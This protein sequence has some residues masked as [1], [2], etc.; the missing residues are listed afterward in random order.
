MLALALVPCGACSAGAVA[1]DDSASSEDSVAATVDGHTI[2]ESTVTDHIELMRVR[3]G[4]ED[5][6]A[7]QSYLEKCDMTAQSAREYVIGSYVERFLVEDYCQQAGITVEDDEVSTKLDEMKSYYDGVGS[8][9]WQAMLDAAGYSDE[10][11]YADE[12]RFDLLESKLKEEK[13]GDIEA[14]DAEAQNYLDEHCANYD[15]KRLA[16]IVVAS[17]QVACTLQD[18]IA[19]GTLS[20]GE[21]ALTYSLMYGNSLTASGNDATVPDD[22][23]GIRHDVDLAKLTYS[24]DAEWEAALA[25]AGDAG[26]S[27]AWSATTAERYL[28]SIA[29][30]GVGEMRVVQTSLGWELLLVSDAYDSASQGAELATVPAAVVDAARADCLEAKRSDAWEAFGQSLW[31]AATIT[32][33]DM[34]DNL[35]YA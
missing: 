8:N 3:D 1:S 2:M 30:M 34:P 16:T 27:Y 32:I 22:A 23:D 17:E 4:L 7:W 29:S 26:W 19:D 10:S 21:A 33:S 28:E 5:A 12:L 11:S 31:A 20:F 9:G 13:V 15:G 35:S 18:R 25:G 24:D 6:Q 14:D